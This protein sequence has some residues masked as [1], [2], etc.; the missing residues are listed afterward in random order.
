MYFKK[1]GSKFNFVQVNHS[2]HLKINGYENT[3]KIQ[4]EIK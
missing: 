1:A 3:E 2:K 4:N